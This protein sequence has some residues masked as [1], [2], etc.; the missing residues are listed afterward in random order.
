[1]KNINIV[2]WEDFTA[3][4]FYP[5]TLTRPVFHLRTGVFSFLER[6]KFFFQPKSVAGVCRSNISPVIN[7]E[8]I[9]TDLD[10]IDRRLP[11]LFLN[12]RAFF[13]KRAATHIISIENATVFVS[14]G[15]PVAL[16]LPA[17]NEEWRKYFEN[18]LDKSTY[19]KIMGS[20][21]AIE[22][23]IHVLSSLW[24]IISL[25]GEF[26]LEDFLTFFRRQVIQFTGDSR[27]ALYNPD[28]IYI[29]P[30]V[31]TDAYAVLDAREGPI[32]IGKDAQIHTGAY[33]QGPAAIGVNCQIMPY[34]RFREESSVGPDC[35]IG[36]EIEASIII[37]HSNKYHDGFLGHSYIGE[38][39]NFGALTTNSDLKNNYHEI[40]VAMPGEDVSTGRN[41]VGI[42]VGDHAKFGIGTLMSAGS[43]VGI[44]AN[45]YGGGTLAK[46]NPSFIW[47]GYADGFRH[48]D[49]EK[50]IDT[51]KMVMKRRGKKMFRAYELVMRSHHGYYAEDRTNYIVKNSGNK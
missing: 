30:G 21:D 4:M 12:G 13:T 15:L 5:L 11:T 14:R 29:S 25:N 47:G 10:S 27:V 32:I 48:Y 33:I 45:L 34:T 51:A 24:E 17:G 23:D 7:Y 38:W 50:A 44:S 20:Y 2:L 41:K 9:L 40:R 3:D 19:Q 36:G 31:R 35:R 26:I 28:N 43:T 39:V 1:M 49:L 42:F 8:G 46:Y 18:P 22:L 6:A 37:G 16:Y